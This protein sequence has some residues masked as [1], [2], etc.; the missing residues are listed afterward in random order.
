[1]NYVIDCSFSSALFLPDE[2]SREVSDFFQNSLSD[3]DQIYVPQLWWYETNNVICVS[4][5]RK[6]LKSSQAIEVIR[7]LSQLPIQTDAAA[8]PVYSEELLR[9]TADHNISSYDAAYLELALR[10]TARLMT[11][12]KALGEIIVYF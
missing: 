5:R 8:G 3:E 11:L 9:I 4:I 12:D 7:L 2:G 1:M 10:K 6:R